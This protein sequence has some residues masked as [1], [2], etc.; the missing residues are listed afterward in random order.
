MWCDSGLSVAEIKGLIRWGK[1][2][3][4]SYA[5]LQDRLDELD[6]RELIH[7]VELNE[8]VEPFSPD[9]FTDRITLQPIGP[10][11]RL[12]RKAARADLA[13]LAEKPVPWGK[14]NDI[15]VVVLLLAADGGKGCSILLPGDAGPDGRRL[16][17]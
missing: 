13:K 11:A 17:R 9:G 10:V 3:K 14:A 6:D 8:S 12:K 16:L 7:F 4:S 2:S 5:K 1:T 15:S